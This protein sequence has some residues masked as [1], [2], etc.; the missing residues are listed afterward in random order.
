M[1]KEK[2]RNEFY[3][4]DRIIPAGLSGIHDKNRSPHIAIGYITLIFAILAGI[5]SLVFS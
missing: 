3:G 2:I 4:L 1:N 5:S